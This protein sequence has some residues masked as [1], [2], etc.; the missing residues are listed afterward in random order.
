MNVIGEANRW[1]DLTRR[2]LVEL[3]MTVY[4]LLIRTTKYYL[5]H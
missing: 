3:L 1:F 4:T 5:S 2:E